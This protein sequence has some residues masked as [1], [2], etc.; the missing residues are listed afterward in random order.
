M[1][2]LGLGIESSEP[3]LTQ[4][5]FLPEIDVT[6]EGFPLRVHWQPVVGATSAEVASAT[7][8]V[9]PAVRTSNLGALTLGNEG[10]QRV[11]TIPGNTRIRSLTL[12][13][14]KTDDGA[15][16]ASAGD[17]SS[18]NRRLAVIVQ[19]GGIVP[20]PQFAVPPISRRNLRPAM[21]TGASLAG[22]VLSLPDVA[23]SRI[24]LNLVEGNAPEEFET[25]AMSLTSVSGVA[26][27]LPRDVEILEPDGATQAWAF[28][29]EMAPETPKQDVDL[30]MSANKLLN[31]ALKAGQELDL[32]FRLKTSNTARLGFR[33][34][35]VRGDLVR[36]F[37]GVISTPLEGKPLRL[38]LDGGPLSPEEPGSVVGD[39]HV[40]YA[41]LRLE[42]D[43]SD[44]VPAASGD[45]RGIVVTDAITVRAFPRAAFDQRAPARV[46]LIGR[47]P[48][49]CELS[50]QLVE[51]NGS[52]PGK[53]LAPPSVQ[54]LSPTDRID[55]QWFLMAELSPS[56]SPTGL[57]VRCTRGRFLWAERVAPM[58]QVAVRDPDPGGRALRLGNTA[59]LNVVETET[60]MPS[61]NFPPAAFRSV[62]PLVSS[63]LFLRVDFGD[64]KLRYSR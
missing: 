33:F 48:V 60:I 52:V 51:M 64:L 34:S 15:A 38:A 54:T 63:D 18:R 26:A 1:A 35:G 22:N 12:T 31:A 23:G 40:V 17:L 25:R 42:P 4:E 47:A 16:A 7:A 10:E 37:P 24:R 13:G 57:A 55:T 29:D 11:V 28:P 32:S 19:S 3:R 21:L 44:A 43:L 30:R 2:T 61:H 8:A 45:V 50:V 36:A 46:G 6:P 9:R 58:V 39:L 27:V 53:A 62:A 14:F 20:A 56:G 41:E 49:E 59:I 5:T